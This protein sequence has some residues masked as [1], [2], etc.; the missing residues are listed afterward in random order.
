MIG[1]IM[2]IMRICLRTKILSFIMADILALRPSNKAEVANPK[3]KTIKGWK[4]KARA[5]GSNKPY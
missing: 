2:V 4:R 5:M 3:P 1:I